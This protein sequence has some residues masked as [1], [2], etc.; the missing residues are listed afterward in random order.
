MAAQTQYPRP[1]GSIEKW[2]PTQAERWIKAQVKAGNVEFRYHAEHQRGVDYNV[3]PDD[4]R[5]AILKGKYTRWEPR[6]NPKREPT[7]NMTFKQALRTHTIGVVT[8]ISDNDPNV[9]VV[10]LWRDV[11][12]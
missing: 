10:T 3:S 12:S 8:S 6:E 11:V 2:S 1:N 9:V 5:E 4:A 7:M